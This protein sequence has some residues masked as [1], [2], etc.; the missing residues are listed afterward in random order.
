M[1]KIFRCLEPGDIIWQVIEAGPS[2]WEIIKRPVTDVQ[3]PYQRMTGDYS[4]M[5]MSGDQPIGIDH[6]YTYEDDPS[7]VAINGPL[8]FILPANE[9]HTDT[10]FLEKADAEAARLRCLY[11]RLDELNKEK[12]KIEDAIVDETTEYL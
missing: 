9:D 6:S 1:K 7:L 5:K 10:L 3:W 2:V 8:G 4:F 12:R 11:A